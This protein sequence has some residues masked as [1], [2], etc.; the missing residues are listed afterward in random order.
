MGIAAKLMT[1]AQEAMAETFNAEYV[2]LHVRKSNRAAFSLYTQT[3]GF[4]INDIEAKY[5]A[6]SEDAYDMRKYLSN[7]K[8]G[9]KA[10]A[11]AVTDGVAK[12][13]LAETAAEGA[14]GGKQQPANTLEGEHEV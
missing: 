3:L 8:R 9:Q 4:E 5:Y 13:E 11:A 14:G 7:T 12:L 6:D 10:D 2:S 1:A